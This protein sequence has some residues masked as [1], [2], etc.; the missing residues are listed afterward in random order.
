MHLTDRLSS[1]CNNDV[2]LLSAI[3]SFFPDN[4]VSLQ[5]VLPLTKLQFTTITHNPIFSR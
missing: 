4:L 3:V 2:R 1:T 5:T